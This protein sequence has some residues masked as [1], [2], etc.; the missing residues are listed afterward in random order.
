[1]NKKNLRHNI[2]DFFLHNPSRIRTYEKKLRIP[3]S[4]KK[5]THQ[6]KFGVN[7]AIYLFF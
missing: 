7:A 4:G 3:F 2:R 6:Q 5:I 1:M